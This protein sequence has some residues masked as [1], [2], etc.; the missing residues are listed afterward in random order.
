MQIPHHPLYDVQEFTAEATVNPE[1]FATAD[2]AVLNKG[3]GSGAF[4][5][6]ISNSDVGHVYFDADEHLESSKPVALNQW[7]VLA[8]LFDGDDQQVL[9][10]YQADAST[11]A[12]PPGTNQAPLFIG[13]H[14]G[15][16]WFEGIIDSVR[17][18]A[19]SLAPD[20]LL[21]HPLAQAWELPYSC[22]QLCANR[23]CGDDVSTGGWSPNNG[24]AEN[25]H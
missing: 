14:D 17:L 22:V 6:E 7:G 5:V 24:P 15:Y 3:G 1:D 12:T 21:H 19:R 13:S 25:C 9:L 10:D 11:A 20:E 23:D 2:H 18:M 8:A 4:R 16:G